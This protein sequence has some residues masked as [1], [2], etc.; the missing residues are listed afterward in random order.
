MKRGLAPQRKDPD[1]HKI[2]SMELHNDPAQRDGGLFYRSQLGFVRS[3]KKE[4]KKE[5]D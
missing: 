3:H 2:E 4:N 1:T 5:F